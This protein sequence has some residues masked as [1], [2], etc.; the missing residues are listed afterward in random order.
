MAVSISALQFPSHLPGISEFSTCALVLTNQ[1]QDYLQPQNP[2]CLSNLKLISSAV[3]DNW[4]FL[5]KGV[6]WRRRYLIL[7]FYVA[8]AEKKI[9]SI[10]KYL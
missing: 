1:D 7:L 8:G 6:E 9:L 5:N 2:D 10:E 3:E 4:I